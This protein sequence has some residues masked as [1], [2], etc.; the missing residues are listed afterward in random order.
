MIDP[1]DSI[2]LSP[3]EKTALLYILEKGPTYAYN[4]SHNKTRLFNTEKTANTALNGLSR[5]GL[6]EKKN[7]SKERGRKDYY[8]TLKGLCTALVYSAESDEIRQK[9]ENIF[10]RWNHLLPLLKKFSLFKKHGL[11]DY[12]KET[13]NQETKIFVFYHGRW[14][15][16]N[17]RNIEDDFIERSMHQADAGFMMKW[18]RVLQEDSE[19]RQKTK[20]RLEMDMKMEEQRLSE[21]I[22]R[23]SKVFPKL[24]LLNPD[25]D[26]ICKIELKLQKAHTIV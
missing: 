7:T 2:R 13:L 10:D 16:N 20:C 23:L 14:L 18:N 9:I 1:D 8:L 17:A 11:E 3:S 19:L 22:E 21:Y 6:L 4:L 5:K 24:E 12:F 15:S 25:W 26:E